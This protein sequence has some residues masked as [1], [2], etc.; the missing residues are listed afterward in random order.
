MTHHH[1]WFRFI[2]FWVIGLA[3]FTLLEGIFYNA[4]LGKLAVGV[5]VVSEDGNPVKLWIIPIRYFLFVLLMPINLFFMIFVW[6][7]GF[8]HDNICKTKVVLSEE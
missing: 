4:S 8:F 7:I 2:K 3:Y 5:K 6:N 1:E